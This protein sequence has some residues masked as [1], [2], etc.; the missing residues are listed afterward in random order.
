MQTTLFLVGKRPGQTLA[1]TSAPGPFPSR[2][3]YVTDRNSG[4]RFLVDTGAEA[5]V[6]PPSRT[7]R[8]QQQEGPGLQAVNGTPIATYGRRSL[9]LDFGLRRT[10]RWVFTIAN[11]QTPII[12]ADFLR[13]FSLLVDMRQH[14]LSDALT[15]LRIQGIATHES[16]P[17][18]T[19][20]PPQ[21]HN[22]YEAILTEY[23]AVMRPCSSEHPVKHSVT[24]HITTTGPP[25]TARTRRLPPERLAIARREFDHMLQLGIVRPSSSSWA[26]PLHMVPKKSAGDWRPC[27][28]Y[29]AL[30]NA[31]TP[32]RYPIPHIQDFA[33]SLHGTTIFSKIDLVRAY[34][35]IP[36]EPAD[37]PKTAVTT[38]FGL[39]EF[40]RMPFGLRNAAQTFQRF[41]DQVLQGLHFC[42]A[43]IDDLLI[44]SRSTDE[45]RQH[46]HLVL[47]RLSDHGI[48]IN[49]SKCA[50]G[51]EQLDFLGHHVDSQ[52][53]R[54]L[55][56]KVQAIREFPQPT[57]QRKLREFLGLINFYHRFIPGAADILH[58]LN[59]I[60]V[61]SKD[62]TKTVQW[63]DNA[64]AAFVAA[65]EALAKA[66]L[67]SHP[68][69]DAPT[70]ITTDAS[71][72][73]VGAVL[74]QYINHCWCPIA[75]FSKKLQ[76]AETRYS[77]FDR[78]LLAIYLAIKHFRHFIEGRTF[79]ILTDH[80]PLT[81][82]MA[83]QS[84][85][86]SPRQIRHLDY[87]SQFTSDI[88][89]VK[90]ANN[91]AADALSRIGTNA[92][93]VTQSSILDFEEIAAAQESDPDLLRS[94]NS[95]TSLKLSKIPL[96]VSN[97][98]IVCDVSTGVARPLVPAKFRR[99]VFDSLHSLSHP[100]IRA[101]QKLVTTRYVWPGIN[102]DVRRWAK[103]CLQCQ[104]TKVQRHTVTPLMKFAT[105]DARFNNI[106]LDIVGPLPPSR[107]YSYLL[108][109][110]D[111]F[112]RWPEAI[113]IPDI[114][115]E[116]VARAFTTGWISRFG[117]P[118]TV[119]TDR[120]SQFESALWT[121]LMQ[122]LGTK[123]IRTTAYHPIANG[124]IERLH[125]QL[126]AS[127]K[128][129]PN[130]IHWVDSLPFVLLGIRTALKEDIQCTAAELVYG[131]SLRLPGEFFDSTHDDTTN[132]PA[133]Y[134]S[135]LKSAMQRLKATPVRPHP[136]RKVHISKALATCTHVFVRRDAIRKPL[137][138]PYDGPYKVLQRTEKYFVV[139]VKG[140]QDSISLD[141]LKP[142]HLDMEDNTDSVSSSPVTI[143][144]SPASP[145]ITEP[146]STTRVTRSGRQ[147]HYPVRFSK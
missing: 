128:S 38:P 70:N 113:P 16:S 9:T 58:P 124:F 49:P 109:C 5:S 105:P 39:F 91:P 40:H 63:N 20:L 33:A 19:F 120:G 81:Y 95:D 82:A 1:A 12:G 107:G 25:V 111:R 93:Q 130:P 104:K 13:N 54:P 74:Q 114:T 83:T 10:F 90:G 147:V 55:E 117:V 100:G 69:P 140:K 108:T 61:A 23:P 87:V 103:T 37:I 123:R 65:K 116:T 131:T 21:S 85:K 31:T 68:K 30:N 119:T 53:I 3:F 135:Q 35:Q 66:T 50:F 41:I 94:C 98:T 143:E 141:R 26:S 76:P 144:P 2:L 64:L 126:K 136:R 84:D 127:L 137:Q 75:Y 71:N 121:Q 57:T 145:N 42:Y 86:Y 29:R 122:L 125:R 139:E 22:E 56:E 34:H 133:A 59:A 112:T 46:L 99:P 80:K 77:T 146:Q 115:A 72:V 60:L 17:S 15:Q 79:H 45:H 73:A 43:Y 89:H 92:L 4:L 132:D 118:S 106:H 32:D 8:K 51:V 102:S 67:L 97:T 101:T 52:G 24:H 36:V 48:L 6:I 138:P 14:R 28:D 142:A 96:P 62:S 7:D 11:I 110:S 134:V 18:P 27:G 44:A 129:Q 47:E 78:E 88:R